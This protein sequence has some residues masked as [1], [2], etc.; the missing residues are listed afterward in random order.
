MA[1]V[2][3]IPATLESLAVKQLCLSCFKKDRLITQL[4][5]TLLIWRYNNCHQRISRTLQTWYGSKT[6]KTENIETTIGLASQ[7]SLKDLKLLLGSTFINLT[8]PLRK[9]LEMSTT[10]LEW[11][12]FRAKGIHRDEI[13][14]PFWSDGPSTIKLEAMK[15]NRVGEKY[16]INNKKNV[17][18]RTRRWILQTIFIW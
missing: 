8:K 4:E 6:Q 1:T 3:E 13:Q 16:A 14:N 9:L 18:H 2:R 5:N 17:S 11:G 12:K 7:K 15:W 10:R